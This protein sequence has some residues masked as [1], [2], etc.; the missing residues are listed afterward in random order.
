[1]GREAEAVAEVGN[2]KGVVKAL[3][4]PQELI[5]RG[6]IRR[7]FPRS[8]ITALAVDGATLRFLAEDEPVIIYLGEKAAISWAKAIEAAAPTLRSKLGLE[9]LKVLFIG[10]CDDAELQAALDGSL[11]DDPSAANLI[12]ARIDGAEDL[13]AAQAAAPGLPIW[14]VFQKGKGCAF[15]ETAI[16]TAFRNAKYR[17][18]KRCAVS[19][20]LTALRFHPA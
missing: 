7:R 17:D 6:A 3:L 9:K 8:T 5:L 16:R 15:G 13:T 2:E 20:R 4:E 19:D 11:T 10:N 14:T 18:T 12:V 1:M